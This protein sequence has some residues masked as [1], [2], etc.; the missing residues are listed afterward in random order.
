MELTKSLV[1]LATNNVGKVGEIGAFLAPHHIG[2]TTPAQ[3]KHILPPVV[4]D[5]GTLVANAIKKAQAVAAVA[6]AGTVVLADDTGV[7]IAALHNA[8][9]IYVRRWRDHQHDMTDQEIIDYTLTQMRHIS[10]AQRQ[11]TMR[12]AVVV[13]RAQTNQVFYG[14]ITGVILEKPLPLLIPGFPFESLVYFPQWQLS[15]GDLHQLPFHQRP[16]QH[17]HRERAL[18]AALPLLQSWLSGNE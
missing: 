11:V 17:T 10:K 9:G 14:E 15:L 7:E 3:E 18:A 4:E 8:P 1:W 12:S 2:V 13:Q 16:G 6:P 5:G